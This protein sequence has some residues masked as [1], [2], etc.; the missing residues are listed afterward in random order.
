[1]KFWLLCYGEVELYVS[2]D[3]EWCLIVYGCKEV[4]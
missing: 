3:F 4:L 1:M 2:W